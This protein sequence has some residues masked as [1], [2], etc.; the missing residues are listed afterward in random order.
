MSIRPSANANNS[1]IG[2]LTSGAKGYGDELQTFAN[3]DKWLLLVEGGTA[4]GWI[5][6]TYN[7]KDYCSLS[8]IPQPA[9]TTELVFPKSFTLIDDETGKRAAYAFIKVLN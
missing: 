8:E 1:P 9:P 6:I 2:K 3:G 7:G 4:K 5:A